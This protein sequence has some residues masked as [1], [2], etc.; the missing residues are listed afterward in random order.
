M[1]KKTEKNYKFTVFVEDVEGV[2]V[3]HA[4]EAGLVTTADELDEAIFKMGKMLLRHV[5]FAER[6]NRQDQ[7]Y[8]KAPADV[9]DRF[10]QF[11]KE[12]DLLEHKTRAVHSDKIGPL[13]IDQSVYAT[14]ACQI[15]A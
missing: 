15:P 11:R 12:N 3:A 7:I 9:F 4:L 13:T 2:H 6:Y 10:N 8:H 14:A 5:V 1:A